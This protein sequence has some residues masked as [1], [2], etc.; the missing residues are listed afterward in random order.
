MR[1][2]T[3]I[4]MLMRLDAIFKALKKISRNRLPPSTTLRRRF[5]NLFATG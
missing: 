3:I 2:E 1:S 5:K 4:A